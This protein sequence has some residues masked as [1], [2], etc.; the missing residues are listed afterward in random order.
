MSGCG[1]H[2]GGPHIAATCAHLGRLRPA[3][4]LHSYFTIS[5]FIDDHLAFHARHLKG[6]Q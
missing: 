6:A 3:H 4:L 2:G 5:T 1:R